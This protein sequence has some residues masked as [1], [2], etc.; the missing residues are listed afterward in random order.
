MHNGMLLCHKKN[1]ILLF[2]KWMDLENIMLKEISHKKTI[3]SGR[4][5]I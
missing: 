5:G 3:I 1:E 2:T 4:C